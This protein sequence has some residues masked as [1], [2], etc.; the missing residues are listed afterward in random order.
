M[1]Q[2]VAALTLFA[3]FVVSA[4]LPGPALATQGIQ[5]SP[6]VI[7]LFLNWWLPEEDLPRLA[8]YDALVFDADQAARYPER[9]RRLRELNPKIII[10]A[11]VTSEE[12]ADNRFIEP[13]DY[14]LKKQSTEIQD[15][16]YVRDAQGNH[17]A[18]WPNS[19]L[20]NVT[21]KGPTGPTGERWNEY[22]PRFIRDTVLASGLWDGVFLDNTFN[23]ISYF[24][25]SPV[26]LDRDGVADPRDVAD[27]AWRAGMVKMIRRIRELNPGAIIMGNGDG[28]YASLINGV[29]FERFP[30]WSWGPNWKEFRE[31]LT[32]N[33]SPNMATINVNTINQDRPN[34]YQLMR[35]GLTS[36][37]IAGGWYSFDRG[38][39]GH[40]VIWWYDEYEM[41]LGASRSAPR[42]IQGGKGAGI[43]PGVWRR[44]FEQGIA[45]VN[46]T[47]AR[48]IVPLSGV[49]EKL[50][51]Q[52]D[53][54]TNDGSLV[55]SVTLAPH[56]G[57]LLFRR[58]SPQEIRDSAF[59]N[60]AFV[61]VYTEN[62]QQSQ[63]G[64]F[65]Q[66]TDVASGASL[67]STDVDRDGSDDLVTADKGVVTVRF[68][69]GVVKS[70]R[71][72]GTSYV[73]R[74]SLAVQNTNR[75]AAWEII[76]G[77]EGAPPEVRVFSGQGALLQHWLVYHPKFAGGVRVAA[78]DLGGDGLREIV[79]G[80]GPGGGPHIRIWKT[81]GAVWGGGF[82]AF[83]AS[84]S[85]GVSV[86]VGDLNG[87]GKG[88]IIAG[89][90]QGTIPRVRIFDSRG[91]LQK[92]FVLGNAPLAQGISVAASDM[93]GDG[94]AEIVVSGLSAF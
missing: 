59:Q 34:D 61:R 28:T 73:G 27:A 31:A 67:I 83:N 16:W 93:N 30:N 69:S 90:G 65:A 1:W 4:I 37:L 12:I 2:K 77:R 3:G 86:A 25:K 60:G 23:S 22:F 85:G 71:P 80:A 33:L 76:V 79:T 6:R 52:Q 94:K 5:G 57:I 13:D 20:L 66:R 10:L 55:S 51:G 46:S 35:Y 75:D 48:Q 62:G 53:A 17:T 39:Y 49:F 26:D 18:F 63:N 19:S 82:F 87:D 42:L 64:F 47:E 84:E 40:E 68:G 14:P 56:D 36:A 92:E 91:M 29:F 45:L 89:S 72:F 32:K 58:S 38:D 50:R 9:V 8:K 43:V 78:G 21:D 15:A 44:D 41:P 54:T 24:A 7:N 70:F 88:E 11:Y 81:D 74:L